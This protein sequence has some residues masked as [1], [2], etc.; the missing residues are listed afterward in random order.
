M[1][2]MNCCLNAAKAENYIKGLRDQREESL[3][4]QADGRA[5]LRCASFSGCSGWFSSAS[6]SESES[7]SLKDSGA[8]ASEFERDQMKWRDSFRGKSNF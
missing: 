3:A 2:S 4:P 7:V 5:R 8:S 1:P 6:E